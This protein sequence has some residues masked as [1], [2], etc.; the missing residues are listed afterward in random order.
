MR[1]RLLQAGFTQAD[2]ET[3][4]TLIQRTPGAMIKNETAFELHIGESANQ[5]PL[6]QSIWMF[7]ADLFAAFVPV[8]PFAF[9][10][11]ASARTLSVVVTTALLLVL[12]VG[13]GIIGEKNVVVTALQTLAIAATAGGAGLLIGSLI[14]GRPGS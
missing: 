10:P 7:A 3:V 9:L 6:V 8:L 2:A 5:N 13:R 12:G 1:D 11:L 14:S 4:T